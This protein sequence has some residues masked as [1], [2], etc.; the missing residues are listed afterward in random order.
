VTCSMPLDR[1]HDDSSAAV[2]RASAWFRLTTIPADLICLVSI[3]L[4]LIGLII[5]EL[6][7]NF[8]HFGHITVEK[9]GARL[10][11][12]LDFDLNFARIAVCPYRRKFRINCL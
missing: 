2:A 6:E 7:P 5:D 9:K 3:T 10:D 12:T 8:K 11:F 4:D 1:S